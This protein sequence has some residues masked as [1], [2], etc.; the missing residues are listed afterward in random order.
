MRRSPTLRGETPTVVGGSAKLCDITPSRFDRLGDDCYLTLD[1]PWIIPALRRA[2]RIEGPVLE[3]CA[4][5][6][7]LVV[8]L[9]ALGIEVAAADLCAYPDPL[10]LDIVTGAD[11]FELDALAGYRWVVTNLPYQ[12]QNAILRHLLPIAAR[13]GCSVAALARSEWRSAK[14]RRVLVHDNPHFLGEVALTKRPVWM[15]PVTKS[16]RHWFS[17]F[18]WSPEPRPP[19]QDAFLRFAGSN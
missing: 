15:R 10:A 12:D 19:G 3:P 14:A 11:V 9:R 1:A 16:P 4:G 13:D 17:W 2:V 6:G 8:E 5:Q 18:V 7:H